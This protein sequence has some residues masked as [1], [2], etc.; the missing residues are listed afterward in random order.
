MIIILRYTLAREVLH[1]NNSVAISAQ[2][3]VAA[4]C[5]VQKLKNVL[6]FYNMTT[7]YCV[8]SY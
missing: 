7:G 6:Y 1:E 5:L 3:H 2:F 4:V 8:N